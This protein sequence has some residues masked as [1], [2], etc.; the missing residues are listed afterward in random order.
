MRGSKSRPGGLAWL[1]L[2]SVVACLASGTAL[3][4]CTPTLPITPGSVPCYIKVQPIDVCLSNGLG[5]APFNTTS[6][7]GA[8]LGNPSATPPI[9]AAGLDSSNNF[10]NA[11]SSNPIGFTVVPTTGVTNPGTSAGVDITRVLMNN[12]GVELVWLPM[13]KYN[14]SASPNL[15]TLTITQTTNTVAMNCTGTIAGFTLT[16]TRKYVP[17][18]PGTLAV[19]DAL[20]GTRDHGGHSYYWDDYR[21]RRRRHLHGQPFANRQIDND[22]GND[23]RFA[24]REFPEPLA[25]GP[26][27]Q[28]L[29]YRLR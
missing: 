28:S 13:T 3:A 25:A 19:T 11:A 21:K 7:T 29:P 5:C 23:Y 6:T 16:I 24:E 15:T 22:H 20:S 14:S 18:T 10:N 8:P 2:L 26:R 9:P 17:G 1:V 27:H 4:T 12:I